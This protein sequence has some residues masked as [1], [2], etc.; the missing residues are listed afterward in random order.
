MGQKTNPTGFRLGIIRGWDSNW[1]SEENQPA[2][3]VEDEKLREYLHTRL[4]N[5]GLS[6]VIIERTPKR[7]LLTLRTSRPGVIIGKGG[8]QIELLREELKKITSKE[9]QINVSEIKRPELDASLVAQNIAQQLQARVS[10]RRA[11]KTAIASAMRMGAKGIKVRCAGRLG[12]AEM[13]RTEQY[14]EGQIPLHTLRADIDYASSTS[15][16]IYGSIGVT[17]WIFKGEIIGDVDLTPGTQSRQD[18]DS[19]RGKGGDDRGR[20]SRR[21]SRNRNRSNK[22]S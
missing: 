8:E 3:I 11:M 16:T 9:V 12:G 2:L 15:N 10:F 7:I 13:A 17:V 22:N 18:S 14:K 19:G 4:R 6:N 5:G 20:R 21:R 1:F